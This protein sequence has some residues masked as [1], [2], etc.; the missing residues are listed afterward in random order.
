MTARQT[1]FDQAK[2]DQAK[3]ASFEIGYG[4]P[5]KLTQF[6]KGRSGN[7]G[8]RPRREPLEQ[9]KM[10]TLQEAYRG[11]VIKENG[12]GEPALAIQALLRSQMEQAIKGDV[13][14]QR[15]ILNVL[16][17]Y[18]RQDAEKAAVHDY[19][20]ELARDAEDMEEVEAEIW[21]AIDAAP[22]AVQKMNYVEAVQ[23]VRNPPGLNRSAAGSE[24][25]A[26]AQES[27]NEESGTE[28]SVTEESGT[29]PAAP[30]AVSPSP[31]AADQP[32]AA[33]QRRQPR[34]GRHAR[35]PARESTP[36]PGANFQTRRL[37]IRCLRHRAGH[38]AQPSDATWKPAAAG[39]SRRQKSGNSLLNSLF[40]GNPAAGRAERAQRQR[41]GAAEGS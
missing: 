26:S 4:K 12:V 23:R 37:R 27:G 11:I 2:S 39:T 25:G 28:E 9:L 3:S 33:P 16:R 18:E 35:H 36:I 21:D 30:P 7:P 40:S 34:P 13:R 22:T 19:A 10:L 17:D 29:A 32:A 8:G 41:K 6:Q 5:P 38:R 24:T 15:D 1:K 31:P 20:D 14:A